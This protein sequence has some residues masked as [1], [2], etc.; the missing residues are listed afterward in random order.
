[1]GCG[2]FLVKYI[3]FFVNLFFALAGLALLGL[4]IAIQLQLNVVLDTVPDHGIQVAPISAMVIGGIVFVIAFYGCCG[5]IRESNC[6]LVTYAICMIILMILKITLASLIFV[7]MDKIIAEIPLHLQN[8]F[9]TDEIAFGNIQ[10]AFNCCG[11]T[12]PMAY[13]N[14]LSL[15]DS[16]CANAPCQLLNSYEGCNV[17][18]TNVFTTYGITIG[19]VPLVIAAFELV[20]VVFSLCL[21]N[22][23]RNKH[24]RT[25]ICYK[26]YKQGLKMCRSIAKYTLFIVNLLFA[27]AGLVLIAFGI[28][29]VIAVP[30]EIKAASIPFF[31][32]GGIIFLIAFCGCCGAITESKCLLI[33]F[34]IVMAVLAAL[35]IVTVVMF[36]NV[37]NR[38]HDAIEDRIVKNFGETVNPEMHIFEFVFTCCGTNGSISYDNRPLYEEYLPPT[39]CRL[40]SELW[41]GLDNI[42]DIRGTLSAIM[43]RYEFINDI[44]FEDIDLTEYQCSREDA[45]TDGCVDSV[46]N[47]TKRYSNIVIYVF[48]GIICVEG[49]FHQ[50]HHK[51]SSSNRTKFKETEFS[52]NSKKRSTLI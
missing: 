19:I 23:A 24:R 14:P 28:V 4:G 12:G 34:S 3:L 40:D 30:D 20:A 29:V 44:D 41:P 42:D 45:V 36:A 15:P 25:S 26:V 43:E 32:F 47:F 2:E 21:A 8:I 35:K 9:S 46:T 22:H 10:V 5:A 52:V 50:S 11:T 48:V 6:M 37:V 39:C 18:L 16:C 27:L 17:K 7:N 49:G 51:P 13:P 33:L 1:M 38:G 31:V